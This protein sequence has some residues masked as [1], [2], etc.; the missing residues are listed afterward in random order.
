ML[1]PLPSAIQRLRCFCVFIY[2][3]PLILLSLKGEEE[4]IGKRGFRPS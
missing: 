1:F 3:T 2:L 4:E